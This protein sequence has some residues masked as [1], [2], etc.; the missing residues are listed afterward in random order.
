MASGELADLQASA[1]LVAMGIGGL[2]LYGQPSVGS[3]PVIRAGL[4]ALASTAKE[5]GQVR[6]WFAVDEEGGP[7]QRLSSVIGALPSARQM[8]ALWS[9]SRVTAAVAASARAMSSL[10][11]T[12]DLAPVLDTASSS[13]TTAGENARSFSAVASVVASYGLA[14]VKGLIEGGVVPVVKHFPGLGHANADTDLAPALDPPLSDLASVDLVPFEK[15]VSVGVPVVL[16]GHPVVPGLTGG[17]PASLSPATYRLL[18]TGLGFRG[19]AITD[20]LA[21]K[22]IAAAGYTEATAA[23]AAIEAGADM[24]IVDATSVAAVLEQLDAAIASG[25][26]TTGTVDASVE[27]ILDAKGARPCS[28]GVAPAG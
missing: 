18:R 19:V 22:A 25:R 3:G 2:V 9:A 5:R 15:A 24:V 17:L 1:T 28:G 10:G 26:L 16:V 27:R 21:A 14:F 13:D 7:V 6:P 23:A 4:T 11:I 12:M 8:A 20:S